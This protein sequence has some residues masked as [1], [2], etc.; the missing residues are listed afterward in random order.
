M[1][2][3]MTLASALSIRIGIYSC[4]KSC[5]YTEHMTDTESTGIT[6]YEAVFGAEP[7]LPVDLVFGS[8]AKHCQNYEREHKFNSPLELRRVREKILAHAREYD[9]ERYK[10][11][12]RDR[13]PVHFKPG[14]LVM[15]HTPAIPIK[16]DGHTVVRHPTKLL[17]RWT[18]P[19]KV[20]NQ[21]PN[22][23]NVY[24]IQ[25]VGDVKPQVVNVAR[26]LKYIPFEATVGKSSKS[27]NK[28][29]AIAKRASTEKRCR[30]SR[31]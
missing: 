12:F 24:K 15:L 10:R 31:S 1:P 14:E 7:K 8:H 17:L 23:P 5:L 29:H 16:E 3:L 30:S 25:L 2:A 22:N 19:H 11:A 28:S 21:M 26:L 9:K 20:V 4:R 6:P 27:I 18:G 13:Y